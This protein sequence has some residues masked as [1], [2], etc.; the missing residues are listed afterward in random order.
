MFK[1]VQYFVNN[2]LFSETNEKYCRKK[3]LEK[4]KK[5]QNWNEKHTHDDL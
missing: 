2:I 5:K 4:R 1:N 3:E